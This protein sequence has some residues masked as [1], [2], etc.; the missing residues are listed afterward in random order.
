MVHL[1]DSTKEDVQNTKEAVIKFETE[2][3]ASTACLLNNA[4]IDG[5]NVSVELLPSQEEKDAANTSGPSNSSRS[6]NSS[7]FSS[8][9]T[10]SNSSF[11][12]LL[13][14]I[15]SKTKS[16]AS[17][18]SS[19][20]KNFDKTYGVSDTVVSGAST[21]WQSSKKMASG[22]NE[23]YSVSEK[24]GSAMSST[25]NKVSSMMSNSSSSST[26]RSPPP[27]Q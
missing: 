26:G 15:G 10:K 1:Y 21:A 18:V 19:K 27:S 16:L 4:L 7:F 8:A 5:V 13:S 9:A 23:K 3:A 24:V 20:V 6:S 11:S 22:I 12:S 2:S 25:K 17:T 14:D